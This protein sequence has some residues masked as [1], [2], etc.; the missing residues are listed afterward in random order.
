M[1]RFH[2]IPQFT[3][4]AGYGVDVQ[5]DYLERHLGRYGEYPNGLD[6]DPD[7][8]RGHVWTE[9]QQAAYVEHCLR[10]GW[11]SRVLL[12]NCVG[13]NHG[14]GDPGPIV[15]VDGKQ[16]LTAVLRFLHDEI[17]IFGGHRRCD[18]TDHMSMFSA[19]FR[20]CV[21]DLPTRAA[22]LNWY[23]ELNAGGTPHTNA[24]LD[25]VRALLKVEVAR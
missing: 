4:M 19:T 3:K 6:L 12:F 18:Y 14:S 15:L 16:R 22:V 1:P 21:N 13:W 7:F 10:G 23:I 20:V 8:Q 25:K 9:A 17:S 24:E 5:W 2:D 11:A